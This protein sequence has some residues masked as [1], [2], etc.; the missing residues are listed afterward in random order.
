MKTTGLTHPRILRPA[1]LGFLVAATLAIGWS[2]A[3][4]VDKIR[5]TT[6]IGHVGQIVD[7]RAKGIAIRETAGDTKEV[8]LNQI[9]DISSDQYPNLAKAEAALSK[10]TTANDAASLRT[11]EGLYA[12]MMNSSSPSWLRLL[13]EYR[14]FRVYAES[15]RVRL[16]VDTY[17]DLATADPG[18]VA[19]MQLPPPA[20]GSPDNPEILK[21]VESAIRAAGGKPYTSELATMRLAIVSL[22]GNP[23]AVLSVIEQQIKNPDEKIHIPAKFE[24][25]KQLFALN[26]TDEAATQLEDVASE[27][28][29]LSN[30]GPYVVDHAYWSGRVYLVRK[31]NLEAALSFMR[32]AILYPSQDKAR[33]AESLY[34]AGQA[35]E[36]AK[37]AKPEIRAVYQEATTKYSGTPGAEQAK[38]AIAKLGA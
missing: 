20:P 18:L 9:R 34:Y 30:Q 37:A 4:A 13:C 11:A 33:T 14:M 38:A 22:S 12:G 27:V 35:L 3:L 21:K 32:V 31:Q 36:A 28:S 25:V 8:P 5:E 1:I 7:I 19:G 17:V 16:A 26:R 29:S 23:E 6:G 10:A 15:G 2:A 24:R